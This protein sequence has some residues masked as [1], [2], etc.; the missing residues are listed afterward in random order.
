MWDFSEKFAYNKERLST[1]LFKDSRGY[2]DDSMM[3]ALKPLQGNICHFAMR[4]SKTELYKA[5]EVE[6][7]DDEAKTGECDCPL[8]INYLLPCRH[9]LPKDKSNALDRCTI[10]RR[11]HL[12][13]S[14]CECFQRLTAKLL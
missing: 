5:W 1:L 7:K 13:D 12:Q 9:V 8:R 6:D 14:G 4:L 2:T 10:H 3:K 11:W